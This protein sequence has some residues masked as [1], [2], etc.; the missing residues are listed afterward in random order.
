MSEKYK[1]VCKYLNHVEHLV[2]LVLT[3]SGCV[4]Y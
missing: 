1:Q 3:I 4:S 2:I